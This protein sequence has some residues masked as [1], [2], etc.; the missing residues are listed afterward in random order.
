MNKQSYTNFLN[1]YELYKEILDV[2]TIKSYFIQD[3][4]HAMEYC[5]QIDFV[6][7][8][9]PFGRNV[10]NANYDYVLLKNDLV[11]YTKMYSELYGSSIIPSTSFLDSAIAILKNNLNYQAVSFEELYPIA[12]IENDFSFQRKQHQ[13]KGIIFVGRLSDNQLFN[14]HESSNRSIH[15]ELLFSNPHNK[16]IFSIAREHIEKFMVDDDLEK[17]RE[18]ASKLIKKN[19]KKAKEEFL[20]NNNIDNNVNVLR[21]RIIHDIKIK[22]PKKFIDI[23]CGDDDIIYDVLKIKNIQVFANDIALPFILEYHKNQKNSDKIIFTNFNAVDATFTHD[24]FDILLCKNLLHHIRDNLRFDLIT[25]LLEISKEV[26]LIEILHID[27]QN[28]LGRKLHNEFYGGILGEIDNKFYMHYDEI[29]SL[30]VQCN[31]EITL[32]DMVETN[33]GNY[34]Y[35]CIRKKTANRN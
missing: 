3:D 25:H 35:V 31:A 33:N 24:A 2:P 5:L 15:D 8:I 32:E 11:T 12:F 19:S 29:I 20:K 27:E 13:H 18:T 14:S 28:D 23:A 16:V 4:L 9:I 7:L 30:C 26:L 10:T 22:A 34:A 17:E 1:Q 6:A 21:N